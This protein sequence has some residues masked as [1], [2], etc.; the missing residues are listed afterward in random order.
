MATAAVLKRLASR[1]TE[2]EQMIQ[3]LRSKIG[4]LRACQ[5]GGSGST[6][7]TQEIQTLRREN[8]QLN[9]QVE[10]W[11]GKLI[12]AENANGVV[13]VAVTSAKGNLESK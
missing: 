12:A 7:Y 10:E 2:A 13:Q 1:A 6:G 4:E 5:A 11:K 8:T 3:L 9:S